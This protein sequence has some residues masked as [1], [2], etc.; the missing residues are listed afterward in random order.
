MASN[1]RQN[2]LEYFF[3]YLNVPSW[4]K[5]LKLKLTVMKGLLESVDVIQSLVLSE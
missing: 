3:S 2:K 5:L 4:I 1:N